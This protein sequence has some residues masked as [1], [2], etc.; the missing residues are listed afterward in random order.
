MPPVKYIHKKTHGRYE[1]IGEGKFT[2]TLAE[3]AAIVMC[4][5]MSVITP[6]FEGRPRID[7]GVFK[8]FA[9]EDEPINDPQII[10]KFYGIFTTNGGVKDVVDHAVVVY[11]SAETGNSYAR[12]TFEFD[13]GRFLKMDVDA[14]GQTIAVAL[15]M[16]DKEYTEIPSYQIPAD[17]KELDER[18]GMQ[19]GH[20]ILSSEE[21]SKG[22]VRPFRMTYFHAEDCQE[23][24]T[25]G[26]L[27]ADTFARD[28]SFYTRTFCAHCRGYFPVAE[29]VWNLALAD[30]VG[31]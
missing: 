22:F 3:G 16:R 10:T 28:P 14:K 29:F 8:V 15:V 12:S 13:D 27:I 11:Q 2:G 1:R 26:R 23:P 25:M 19:K 20:L 17:Y 7:S 4:Q 30:K 9:L 24:T 31:S 5:Y 6:Q 21:T 18:T